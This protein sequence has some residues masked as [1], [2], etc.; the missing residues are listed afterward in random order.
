MITD[1]LNP[2]ALTEIRN[3]L[4]QCRAH[5]GE[6]STQILLPEAVTIQLLRCD[7]VV[8]ALKTCQQQCL[9]LLSNYTASH[10]ALPVL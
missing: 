5:A 2:F 4:F 7:H 1:S 10:G 8:N 9:P 3:V 6:I